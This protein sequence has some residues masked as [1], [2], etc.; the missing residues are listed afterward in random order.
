LAGV[1]LAATLRAA[2]LVLARSDEIQAWLVVDV[3]APA[4]E[5]P[6]AMPG[7]VEDPR[8]G[9][10]D[11]RQGNGRL[12]GWLADFVAGAQPLWPGA[13]ATG[14]TWLL[15]PARKAPEP[16]AGGEAAEERLSKILVRGQRSIP[17]P[18]V[19]W[20]AGLGD[21]VVAVRWGRVEL[22]SGNSS[23]EVVR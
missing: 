10:E 2:G 20:G 15:T 3:A 9:V 1:E 5:A 19:R 22:E 4:G 23:Q 12:A 17:R 16:T 14:E 18:I 11:P 8:Q 7:T 21:A 13:D 6:A